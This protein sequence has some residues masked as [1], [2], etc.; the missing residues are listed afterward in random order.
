MKANNENKSVVIKFSE[1]EALVL[2]EWLHKFNEEER[3]TLI[4]DQS[5][6]R[7]LFD[8]EAELETAVSNIFDSNYQEALLKARQKIRDVE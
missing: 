3:P 6:E 8:L 4:Q 2:L 1:E 5:E 7:I